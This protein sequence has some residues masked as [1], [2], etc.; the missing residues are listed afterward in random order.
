MK[1]LAIAL[2][3]IPLAGTANAV[4]I[5]S[6]KCVVIFD[7]K[8]RLACFDEAVKGAIEKAVPVPPS[9]SAAPTPPKMEPAAAAAPKAAAKVI[10]PSDVNNTPAKWQDRTLEIRN[11]R[12]YW[13]A[14]D[15]V[16][17]LMPGFV[18]MTLFAINVVGPQAAVD[19]YKRECETS[20]EADQPKCRATVRFSYFRH[21]KDKPDGYRDRTVLVTRDLEFV[22]TEPSQRRRRR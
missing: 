19:H 2:C 10:D 20:R 15:D 16:R 21:S 8:E 11:A 22:R 9:A 7:D 12:V 6:S 17:I 14:D 3:L 5:D 4:T 13:V 18:S 1:H